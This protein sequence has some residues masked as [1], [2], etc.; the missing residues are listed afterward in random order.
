MN[1]VNPIISDSDCWDYARSIPA[2]E[3]SPE[4]VTHARK[5]IDKGESPGEV[6][7]LLKV[8]RSTLY[9]TLAG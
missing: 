8:A 3:F 4:Q 9:K 7:K 1:S 6:A 5:L 2:Y